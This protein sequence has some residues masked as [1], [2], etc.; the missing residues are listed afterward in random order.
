MVLVV[1]RR[2]DA[3]GTYAP[4]ASRELP[5][6]ATTV[7]SRVELANRRERNHAG[8]GALRS[9]PRDTPAP[10]AERALSGYPSVHNAWRYQA[11][12]VR[13]SVSVREQVYNVDATQ[14]HP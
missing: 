4:A 12:T 14:L 3:D 5:T 10:L 13:C 1:Q 11:P 2:S 8:G 9:G 7:V 6:A